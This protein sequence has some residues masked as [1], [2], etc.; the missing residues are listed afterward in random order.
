LARQIGGRFDV[1]RTSV[2]RCSVRFSQ[3]HDC[4]H[5]AKG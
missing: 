1:V 5:R 3:D 4:A 2:T